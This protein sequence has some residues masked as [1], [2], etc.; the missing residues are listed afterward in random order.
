[1]KYFLLACVLTTAGCINSIHPFVNSANTYYD[2]SLAGF[3]KFDTTI[4]YIENFL[5]SPYRDTGIMYDAILRPRTA[6]ERRSAELASKTYMI[7][8]YREGLL[9]SLEGQLS[10]INGA[11]YMQLTPHQI[12][13]DEQLTG[14]THYNKAYIIAKLNIGKNEITASF[15]DGGKIKDL[16]LS[17]QSNLKHEYE[18]L[19]DVFV[20]T[21][22]TNDLRKEIRKHAK[23]NSFFP[24]ANVV[25]LKR[26]Q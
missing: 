8:Y 7:S 20:I 5:R 4:V 18:E 2:Q 25:T 3:W 26:V 13:N 21:A 1:M 16:I 12:V 17:G 23:D 10:R 9:Y 14:S 6:A 24:S 15:P 19:F 11:P 22:S